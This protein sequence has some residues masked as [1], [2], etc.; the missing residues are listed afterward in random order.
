MA[1]YMFEADARGGYGMDGIQNVKTFTIGF[2]LDDN[3]RENAEPLLRSTAVR[4]G[5]R[6]Y[7]ANDAQ[8]LQDAFDDIIR[9]VLTDNATFTAPAVTV[10]AFNR[11]RNLD[12]VY[13]SLFRPELNYRWQGNVKKF[14]VNDEGEIVDA[15]GA[16]AVDPADGFL[17]NSSQSYWSDQVDGKDITLGGA[18]GE[19]PNWD[20]GSANARRVYSN[21]NDDTN[22]DLWQGGNQVSAI[23]SYDPALAQSMLGIV[24]PGATDYD[25]VDLVQWLYGRDVADVDADNDDAE[26]RRDM[27]DPLH[28]RPVVLVYGGD[29]DNP[30]INDSVLFVTT[31]DGFLHAIDTGNGRELWSFVPRQLLTRTLQLVENSSTEPEERG[32]GLDGNVRLLIFDNNSNG[33]IEPDDVDGQRDRAL[34]F[35]GM[36][37]GG[38]SYFAM[39][40]TRKDY[41]R[42]L[43]I[44]SSLPGVGQTWSTPQPARVRTD[45]G[46]RLVLFVSGGYS[47]EHED[48]TGT[49]P[50]WQ[51]YPAPD[52]SGNRIYMLDMLTGALVWSA[53]PSGSN[54]DLE[55]PDMQHAFAADVRVLELS[56]DGYAD[57]LYAA[58]LGGKVWRFDINNGRD[59]AGTT[60]GDRLIEGGLFA[61]LGN[62]GDGTPATMGTRRFFYAPDAVPFELFGRSIINIGIGSG[63]RELPATDANTQNGFFSIRDYLGRTRLLSSQYQADCTGATGPCHQIVTEDDLVDLTTTVGQAATDAVQAGAAGWK[64]WLSTLYGE[65]VLAEARTLGGQVFF[66]TYEPAPGDRY[67]AESCSFNFGRNRLYIVD[68]VDARPYYPREGEF[69]TDTDGDGEPDAFNENVTDRSVDLTQTGIASEVVFIFTDQLVSGSTTGQRSVFCLAGFTACPPGLSVEPVR[70]FWRQRGVQ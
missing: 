11:T 32:Y 47:P 29:A 17:L 16:P 45:V 12:D 48:V 5:G 38:Y 63:H 33:I 69:N 13:V 6:Y 37:R 67:F 15:N 1:E 40:V 10:D 53:G 23:A 57:R 44:N 39:D 70:T 26:S 59:P 8:T 3:G 55:L 62:Y 28:S 2:A 50:A 24:D 20:Y 14:R 65:K 4:G 51:Q 35:F 22:V 34:L 56:G 21:L 54:A 25:H 46:D 61:S 64:I 66:T 42:L 68:I 9:S 7:E 49:P 41:P 43:W 52:S 31:N 27:G 18:A 19:I 58:D 60:E 36:R 30:D